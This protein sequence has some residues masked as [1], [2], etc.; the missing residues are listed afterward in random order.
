MSQYPITI[1]G[2]L[3]D[4]PFVTKFSSD[5][6]NTRLRIASSRRTRHTNSNGEFEWRDSD[7]VYIN[8]ELWGQLAINTSKSLKKG[9]PV[10]AL[11]SLCT[12]TW[13]DNETQKQ[14]ERTYMR[15]LQVGIDMNRYIVASQR[16]DAL[17]TPE[18]M[19]LN[20]GSEALH[21]N[22]DY[23]VDKD[24]VIDETGAEEVVPASFDDPREAEAE[25]EEVAV[26]NF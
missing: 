5:K 21:I 15:G 26:A 22:K 12:D 9:M 6:V 11:G 4:D 18:G 23:T 19:V 10:I 8:I 13:T 16:M 14:R 25:K 3:T 2:N 17:H 24:D 20:S 7:T 1:T